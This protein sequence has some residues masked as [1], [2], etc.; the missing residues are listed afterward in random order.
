MFIEDGDIC[1]QVINDLLG[2][3]Y[4]VIIAHFVTDAVGI[5]ID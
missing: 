4:F 2:L 5:F 3:F 1:F